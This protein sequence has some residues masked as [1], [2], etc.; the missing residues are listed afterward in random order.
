MQKGLN[1]QI[2]IQKSYSTAFELIDPL[3]VINYAK[4]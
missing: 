3:L 4:L 2:S 1:Q